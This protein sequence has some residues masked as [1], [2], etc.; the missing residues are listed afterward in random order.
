LEKEG[1]PRMLTNNNQI[2]AKNLGEPLISF[3]LKKIIN[4]PKEYPKQ[5]MG[6]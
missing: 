4:P 1:K 6:I 3:F 5:S 2:M